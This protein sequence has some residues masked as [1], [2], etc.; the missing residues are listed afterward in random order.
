MPTVFS[1]SRLCELG[2]IMVMGLCVLWTELCW[3]V[4]PDRH[5]SPRLGRMKKERARLSGELARMATLADPRRESMAADLSLLTEDM[6]RLE[7]ARVEAFR[8]AH[9]AL[10]VRFAR[11]LE[12]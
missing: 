9:H 3:L 2:R 5:F 6:D 1:Y 12:N 11:E 4:G 7:S 10:R 8:Q